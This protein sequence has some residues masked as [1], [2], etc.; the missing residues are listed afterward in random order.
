MPRKFK[1]RPASRGNKLKPPQNN[2][3]S[4]N[5]QHP[6]FSFK[7]LQEQYG[8]NSCDATAFVTQLTQVSQLTWGAWQQCPRCGMGYEKIVRSSI[9]VA[10]PATI[11]DDVEFFLSFRF[12]KG[13]VIGYRN[14]TIFYI[15]WTDG[16]F[17]VYKH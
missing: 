7:Y 11:T 8:I 14:D 12:S 16:T 6:I 13:R 5:Q 3:L 4:P 15:I 2:S 17:S 1:T 9:K 10:I